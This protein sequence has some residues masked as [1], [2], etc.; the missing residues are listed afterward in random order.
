MPV[1]LMC[2]WK[3]CKVA[4]LVFFFGLKPQCT[5]STLFLCIICCGFSLLLNGD[6][7]KQM[8][9][10]IDSDYMQ[11]VLQA[12]LASWKGEVWEALPVLGSST[13]ADLALL[14][15]RLGNL[16]TLKWTENSINVTLMNLI[17]AVLF[18]SCPASLWHWPSS[19]NLHKKILAI[20]PTCYF[21]WLKC[22]LGNRSTLIKLS[23]W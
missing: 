19:S 18:N 22:Y 16:V 15:S 17:P 1:E 9:P 3:T 10:C 4:V 8:R 23:G 13:A 14:G 6:S 20:K 7:Q 2:T 5:V 12:D 11:V 21:T